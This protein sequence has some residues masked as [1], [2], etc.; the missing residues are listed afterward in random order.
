MFNSINFVHEAV[1]KGIQTCYICGCGRGRP[2]SSFSPLH[3][4]LLSAP[5]TSC[6]DRGKCAMAGQGEIAH[7][8]LGKKPASGEGSRDG[9]RPLV[10]DMEA[11]HK[12]ISSF[13]VVGRLLSPFQANPRAILDDLRNTAWKNQG[14]TTLQEVTAMTGGSSS[15]SPLRVT[16]GSCLRRSLGTLI[17]MG[18]S[19]PSS[20]ATVTR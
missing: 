15:I 7:D 11:A 16:V 4:H 2:P 18:S 17:G 6:H 20:T 10:I 13:L 19:S 12:A 8:V 1:R 5:S 3:N 14:V 9:G